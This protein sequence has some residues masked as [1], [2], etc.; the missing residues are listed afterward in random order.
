[1]GKIEKEVLTA[2]WDGM[3]VKVKSMWCAWDLRVREASVTRGAATR[4]AWIRVASKI[5]SATRGQGRSLYSL[6]AF[7]YYSRWLWKELAR[8]HSPL[9]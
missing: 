6:C 8:G 7:T 9:R 3:G 1:M 4:S 5:L 2:G